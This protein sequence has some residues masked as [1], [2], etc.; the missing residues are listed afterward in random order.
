M[1]PLNE[2]IMGKKMGMYFPKCIFF[3]KMYFE[4][5]KQR[6]YLFVTGFWCTTCFLTRV[7][8]IKAG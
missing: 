6:I 4:N 7:G 5:K 3:P 2:L 8:T 1:V